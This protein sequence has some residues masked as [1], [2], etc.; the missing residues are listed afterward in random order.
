MFL[1]GYPYVR[2]S[3]STAAAT[4]S[5]AQNQPSKSRQNVAHHRDCDTR[6]TRIGLRRVC[7]DLSFDF[8][9][10]HPELH[11]HG[12][13]RVEPGALKPA[14]RL[15]SGYD[16]ST[17]NTWI[18]LNSE[19]NNCSS[20]RRPQ[21]CRSTFVRIRSQHPEQLDHTQ[22][23]TQQLLESAAPTLPLTRRMV[24]TTSEREQQL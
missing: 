2:S 16:R 5:P 18:I 10:L 14:G 4:N 19:H 23:R 13:S 24:V 12:H 8:D 3:K 21:T 20:R 22:Q 1:G 15:S 7:S 6:R 17:Q 11:Q 9:S